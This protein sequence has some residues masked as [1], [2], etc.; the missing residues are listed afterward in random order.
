LASSQRTNQQ[1]LWLEAKG[2]AGLGE[3]APPADMISKI[4]T[5]EKVS[6]VQWF[7]LAPKSAHP[8]CF[9]FKSH[10][11]H[12]LM[13]VRGQVFFYK[14]WAKTVFLAVFHPALP[15][16]WLQTKYN[17]TIIF[18]L[19]PKVLIDKTWGRTSVPVCIYI[20]KLIV[21]LNIDP[22]K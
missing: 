21:S 9:G 15:C 1:H 17:D 8:P 18:G 16:L 7:A 20:F 14:K 6:G 11:P 3:L 2:S 22:K 12:P 19:E 10:W 4:K 13:G 5:R